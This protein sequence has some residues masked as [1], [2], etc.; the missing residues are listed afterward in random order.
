[1]RR[2]GAAVGLAVVWPSLLLAQAMERV[3]F[4]EAV[5][6][7][8][9][10]H[11]TV[12]RAAA[13]IMRADA[14]F[15]QVR[16]RSRPSIDASL[17]TNMIGP[18]TRFGGSAIFPRAQTVTSA[19]VAVPLI[20]PVRWAERN[21]AA[22]QVV[23]SQRGLDEA[24]RQVAV[25]AGEA[26]LM[27]IAERRVLELNERARDNA[28]AHYDYANQRFQGGLG[29]RLNAVRA[30]QEISSNEARVEEA[31][32][33]IR[34]AQE[35]LGVLMAAEG[36]VDASVEPVFDEPAA[37]ASDAALVADR[38]DVRSI[39]AR[40]SAAQRRAADARKDYLP[41]VTA[42][43]APQVLAPSGLFANARS[44]RASVLFSVPLFDSGQRRG[45]ER[46]RLA[47]RPRSRRA[48][49]RG[50]PGALRESGGTGGGGGNRAGARPRTAGC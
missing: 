26:Y 42:L 6:R 39:L 22:D 15:Q 41:S 11:P 48:Q 10:S 14:V 47:F 20:L 16:A 43:F 45:Q 1:M 33:A 2:I 50:T 13:D 38:E 5:R 17:A 30:E 44:W 3:T 32:L 49:Q 29:S 23:V 25:A 24:R 37:A 35:A 19:S 28:R 8:V 31:R 46:E 34:R 4:D 9:A 18:V 21:Q 36:P 40:E 7:A 27:I 12:Q